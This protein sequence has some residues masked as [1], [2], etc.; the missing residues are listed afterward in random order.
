MAITR[1]KESLADIQIGENATQGSGKT[2]LNPLPKDKI[3]SSKPIKKRGFLA[4][5]IDE[6]R[7]VNWPTFRYTITWSV[8]VLIFTV[9]MSIFMGYFDHL[10]K[11]S[12]T[13]VQ[14]TATYNIEGDKAEKDLHSCNNEYVDTLT[15][16]K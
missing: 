7:K 9:F 1:T 4:T 14:C 15:F 11:N 8:I 13:Y 5:T 10:F 16:K 2:P 6:L 3:V 12:I